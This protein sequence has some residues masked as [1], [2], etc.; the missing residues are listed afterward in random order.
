MQE[1]SF[2]D[3]AHYQ[4]LAN[5]WVEGTLSPAERKELEDWYAS[6]Q[7]LPVLL[8]PGFAAGEA[9]QEQQMLQTIREK[10]GL[11]APII[12]VPQIR[13]T[14]RW[15][16]AAVILLSLTGSGYLLL[17]HPAGSPSK[18]VTG[19]IS[20]PV[21]APG[22]DAAILT[23]SGGRQVLL[24][25]T[26]QDTVL[27]EGN[28]IV[29]S[30]G[31]RLAY[32]PG[33]SSDGE[34]VFN[35]LST[36]RGGQYQLTLPDGTKAWLNAAS[37][38]TYPTTFTGTNRSVTITGEVYFEVAASPHQPFIVT[39]GSTDITVLGTHF[40]VMA[41]SDESHLQ[42]TLIEGAVQ[43]HQ[44][45]QITRLHPGEQ[46]RVD[47]ETHHIGVKKV[48]TDDAIAWVNGRLSL[49][50]D[51]IRTLMRQISRWYDVDVRYE[52]ILPNARLFGTI[53]RNINLSDVLSSL[54]N[55]GIKAE[56]TGNTILVS[57]R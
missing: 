15:V 2:F 32:N 34:M 43:V 27:T 26:L 21:G 47:T 56:L 28:A 10:V 13:K 31:G 6:G 20:K 22:H 16:A 48:E 38:I 9:M 37:S 57:A 53:S 25:N 45:D 14:I 19:A 55:F 46:A 50:S 17:H 7:D 35:T 54:G 18:A 4:E 41:Y 11:G 52:G 5:K 3:A 1:K 30:A 40:D 8:P 42:T 29:A 12:P 24:G 36:A 51:D 39:A 49:E 33:N 23:L 44:G